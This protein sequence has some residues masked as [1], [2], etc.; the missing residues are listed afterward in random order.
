MLEPADFSSLDGKV[1]VGPDGPIARLKLVAN[2]AIQVRW[3]HQ[4]T[5]EEREIVHQV[6][7]ATLPPG[8]NG[9]FAI[10]H[11]QSQEEADEQI[12]RFKQMLKAQEGGN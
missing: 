5:E 3:A 12:A 4:P 11:P 8:A 7:V 2:G 9:V 10:T 1:V 6:I